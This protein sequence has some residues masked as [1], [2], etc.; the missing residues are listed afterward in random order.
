MDP[1]PEKTSEA[2]PTPEGQATRET[3]TVTTKSKP[4]RFRRPRVRL[5]FPELVTIDGVTCPV[6]APRWWIDDDAPPPRPAT[7]PSG[8][9]GS[10]GT[11]PAGPPAADWPL[12]A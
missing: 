2:A 12:L 5:T 9:A 10:G 6:D 8:P 7:S 4:Q 1:Q 3:Q 11:P